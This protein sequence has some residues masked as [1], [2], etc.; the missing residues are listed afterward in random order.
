M[1]GFD[2]EGDEADAAGAGADAAG[3]AVT[4]VDT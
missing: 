4:V 1:I 3:G 2:S